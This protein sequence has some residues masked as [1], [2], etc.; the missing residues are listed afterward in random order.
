MIGKSNVI[1]ATDFD[2]LNGIIHSSQIRSSYGYLARQLKQELG[3]GNVVSPTSVPKD[4]V[5]M[6]SKVSIRDVRTG[7]RESY[8]LAYPAEANID[9]DRLSVL[10]PL[11]MAL[12]GTKAGDVVDVN[13]P[14]GLRR[15]KVERILYQPEAAGDL[16]R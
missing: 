5:T 13:T 10:A 6:N 3:R 14:S 7:A 4:V 12:L 11:G 16:H 9:E 1:T 8:T 15:I 2:R